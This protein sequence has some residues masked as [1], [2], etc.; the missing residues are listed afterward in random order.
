[1]HTRQF[2]TRILIG[3]SCSIVTVVIIQA[4]FSP[5]YLFGINI[6]ESL[7]GVF[8]L[9][10]RDELP[11]R[12]DIAAF[13][14]PSNPYYRQGA[15]FIKI[16][17]GLPGDRVIRD[18]RKF[19]INDKLVGIAKTKTRH[20]QPLTLGPT[21]KIPLDH[22]FFWTPHPDSYDSRYGEIGWISTDRIM[23]RAVRIL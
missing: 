5:W 6:D 10:I 16:V 23:G 14:T 12:D 19:F 3:L 8:Y 2:M 13:R 22:Y 11:A 9:V 20:G 18:K 21:G 17:R 1:M 15:P 4:A 7:P